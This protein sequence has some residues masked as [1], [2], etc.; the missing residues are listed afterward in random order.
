MEKKLK[1]NKKQQITIIE[2]KEDFETKNQLYFKIDMS[3]I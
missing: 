3:L 2:K 1:S